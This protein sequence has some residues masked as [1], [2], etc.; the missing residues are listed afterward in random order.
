V[1]QKTLKD[2]GINHTQSSPWQQF[3]SIPEDNLKIFRAI[4]TGAEAPVRVS[5][6]PLIMLVCYLSKTEI[7]P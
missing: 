6:L 3:A 4:K 7:L 5:E 1:P 2:I